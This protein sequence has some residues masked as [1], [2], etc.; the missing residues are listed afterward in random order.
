MSKIFDLSGTLMKV[1]GDLKTSNKKKKILAILSI[2]LL[3][4][5]SGTLIYKVFN[6]E[7]VESASP[8]EKMIWNNSS[9]SVTK[10]GPYGN[11]KSPIKIAYIVGQHPRESDAHTAI[12]ET[13]KNKSK[14]LKYCYYIYSIN[15][16]D[17]PENFDIGRAK[18]QLLSNQYVV[19]DINASNY[20]LAV[21]IHSYC[22]RYPEEPIVFSPVKNGPSENVALNLSEQISWLKYY[23][24]PYST[25]PDYTT[26]PLINGGTPS[27]VF[28]SLKYD[29]FNETKEHADEF[30]SMLDKLDLN[31]IIQK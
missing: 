28:E 15:V 30:V 22:N 6:M 26:I 9:G 23:Y 14:S 8:Q 10:E 27:I 21:D 2:S 17:N 11:A 29:S 25:S 24:L 20:T 4:L 1:L 13:V 7:Q 18:G 31:S 12:T 5:L 16:T 19:P 3:F